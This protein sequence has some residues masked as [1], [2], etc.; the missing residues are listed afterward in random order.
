MAVARSSGGSG[1]SD[2]SLAHE[3][4]PRSSPLPRDGSHDRLYQVGH[5]L[6]SADPHGT[7]DPRGS[8]AEGLASGARLCVRDGRGRLSHGHA[9]TVHPGGQD[10]L[11]RVAV[12]VASS[13]SAIARQRACRARNI[14][15]FTVPTATPRTSAVSWYDSP[16]TSTRRKASRCSV[17]T[18]RRAAS[19][20]ARAVGS[21][22]LLEAIWSSHGASDLRLLRSASIAQFRTM[23]N[24][25]DPNF[26][27]PRKP[28]RNRKARRKASWVTSSASWRSRVRCQAKRKASAW[29]SRTE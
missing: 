16:N 25:H 19:S 7:A 12:H 2:A 24:S 14:L 3:G 20:S 6:R 21:A 13:S 23:L 18:D 22:T 26:R 8:F 4:N 5:R 28:P 11:H 1:W 9:I 27:S 15:L 10:E 17:E 29:N